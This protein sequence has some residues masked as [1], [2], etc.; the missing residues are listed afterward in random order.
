LINGHALHF[1]AQTLLHRG[2]ASSN[3]TP[4]RNCDA[5]KGLALQRAGAKAFVI[6][7]F[8]FEDYRCPI[9]SP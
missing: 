6:S 2:A 9:W 3:A 1:A 4:S 5:F 7:R 8:N